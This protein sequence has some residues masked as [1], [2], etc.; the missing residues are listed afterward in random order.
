[1]ATPQLPSSQ[2]IVAC[3]ICLR[4][5]GNH[6]AWCQHYVAPPAT[7]PATT[8]PK[9]TPTCEVNGSKSASGSG[10]GSLLDSLNVP[11][12]FAFLR[13]ACPPNGATGGGGGGAIVPP[14]VPMPGVPGVPGVPGAGT[15][16]GAASRRPSR[17]PSHHRIS[18]DL[19][20]ADVQW[21]ELSRMSEG[22]LRDDNYR[23]IS[24]PTYLSKNLDPKEMRW[25]HVRRS[26]GIP[27][28]SGGLK[29][30]LE[31]SN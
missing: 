18:P 27:G 8:S 28:A 14:T 19:L 5:N 12:A 21:S 17:R 20:N 4:L 22:E 24:C 11:G 30:T 23:V 16:A 1:M 6:E 10:S 7:T 15:P 13:C 2:R 26:W 9:H 31:Y 29:G 3:S 25:S